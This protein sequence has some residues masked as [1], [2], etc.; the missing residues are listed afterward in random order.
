[1]I[2]NL[3]L[4]TTQVAAPRPSSNPKNEDGSMVRM[5]KRGALAWTNWHA[6]P[7][8]NL[9]Q[10]GTTRLLVHAVAD[11]SN[12]G[13]IP[14]VRAFFSWVLQHQ[15]P[16]H[17]EDDIDS[18]MATYMDFLCYDRQVSP[19]MGA[20]VMFGM[21]CL[22]PRLRGKLALTARSMKAWSKLAIT[23]EGG[24]VPEEIIFLIAVTMIAQGH[25]PHG[26][27]VLLQYDIYGR[28]QDVENLWDADMLWDGSKLALQFGVA[29]RGSSSKT[30]VNQGN[31]VRR[32]LVTDL[33]LGMRSALRGDVVR[34]R[35]HRLFGIS[36]AE[37]RK[38]W[39]ACCFFLGVSFAGAPH[40]IRHSGPSEDIDR[41]RSDLETV[42]RRGRWKVL[43]SVQRYTKSFALTRF[44]A[45]VPEVT[46]ERADQVSTTM[47]LRQAI[48]SHLQILAKDRQQLPYTRYLA[49]HLLKAMNEAQGNEVAADTIPTKRGSKRSR[50]SSAALDTDTDQAFGTDSTEGWATD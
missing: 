21:L 5:E 2:L 25:L 49:G 16:M 14:K 43:D 12:R 3:L 7:I 41:G 30:G 40:C 10:G 36:S 1:M 24:P 32:A 39:H 23:S 4:A 34:R 31:I 44:R 46:R 47:A 8:A 20:L 37:F 19:S 22:F 17:T 29:A 28:E 48:Y 35:Q 27:W 11:D 38:V 6:A 50:I 9:Q 15:C 45:R 13:W 18:T 26:V 42:R 33:M